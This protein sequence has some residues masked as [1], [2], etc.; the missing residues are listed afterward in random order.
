M[1]VNSNNSR[2]VAWVDSEGN[3][4]SQAQ[5]A[6][7][8]H[9]KPQNF[10]KLVKKMPDNC[11][12]HLPDALHWYFVRKLQV[13][14]SDGVATPISEVRQEK[15]LYETKRAKH[16]AEKSELAV[17]RERFRMAVDQGQYVEKSALAQRIDQISKEFGLKLFAFPDRVAHRVM[18]AAS[19]REVVDLLMA[20]LRKITKE[21]D[22]WNLFDDE[23][24]D[25]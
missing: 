24:N 4:V 16:D 1:S 22:S 20:E 3:S 11:L 5:V 17:E 6:R 9:L 15:L 14:N 25:F 21:I 7:W 23:K 13:V 19:A 10:S 8:L 2:K 18:G 12:T